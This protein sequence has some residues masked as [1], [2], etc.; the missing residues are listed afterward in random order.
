MS[1]HSPDSQRSTWVAISGLQRLTPSVQPPPVGTHAPPVQVS[2]KSAQSSSTTQLPD[3]S[4]ISTTVGV[5][6][7]HR[8]WS[9][10][11]PPLPPV[12]IPPAQVPPA[13]EQSLP[14]T[15]LLDR[16]SCVAS[17]SEGSHRLWPSVQP[18]AD[19]QAPPEQTILLLAQFSLGF[20]L[21]STQLSTWS[22]VVGLQ[23]VWVPLQSV[24]LV[25][26][27]PAVQL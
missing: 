25:T 21:P 8:V 4:Q 10:M 11:Q 22:V 12:Q 19:S 15:Q 5:P 6:L 18:L 2:L 3:M 9:S 13:L 14:A 24:P 23:R 20:Q 7:L 26:H 1:V 16:Q 27:S 17:G